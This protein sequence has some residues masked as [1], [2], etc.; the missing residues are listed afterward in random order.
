MNS[1]RFVG[2]RRPKLQPPPVGGAFLVSEGF[3]DPGAAPNVQRSFVSERRQDLL[4]YLGAEHYL[5]IK[6]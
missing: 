4:P 1:W 2:S 3:F 5:V 6:F